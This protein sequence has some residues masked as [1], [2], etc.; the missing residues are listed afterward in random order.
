MTC[1]SAIFA[2]GGTVAAAP[3]TVTDTSLK[4]MIANP[5]ESD[6]A[7]IQLG[8]AVRM[9]V[10]TYPD[11]CFVGSIAGIASSPDPANR[12]AAA[13]AEVRDPDKLLHPGMT[14]TFTIDTGPR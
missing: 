12:G 5:H 9:K 2:F 6:L 8:Q 4:W 1:A 13:Y 10:Q 14:A 3:L 7:G 11:Q